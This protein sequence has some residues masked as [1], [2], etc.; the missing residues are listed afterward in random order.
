MPDVHVA[1]C[2]TFPDHLVERLQSISPNVHVVRADEL[3]P[4]EHELLNSDPDGAERREVS[5]KLDELLRDVDV[6]LTGG[7][8]VDNFP[9]RIPN[10]KWIQGIGAGMDRILTVEGLR[11][12]VVLTNARGMIAR[13]IAEWVIGAMLSFAKRMPTWAE[14]KRAHDYNRLGLATTSVQG[15]TVGIL[16]FGNIGSEVGRIARVLDMRVLGTKR[17]KSGGRGDEAHADVVYPMSETDAVI[18]ASDYLVIALPLTEETQ[19][20]V[21]R[22]RIGLMKSSAYLLNVGRGPIVDQSALIDALRDGKIAGAA[23]DVFDPEPLPKDSPLWDLE[24]VIYSPHVSGF[25]DDY[26]NRVVDLF[27]GNLRRYLN[28]E[29]L[30]NIVDKEAGY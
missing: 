5:A 6:L 21:D 4:R 1:I 22:R 25:V 3:I 18:E 14:R 15:K 26:H 28:G 9:S 19:Q 8:T 7:L 29:E 23:L 27:E 12:E 10:L 11:D 2:W 16:G 17:G 30:R 24:N 13:P 20:F